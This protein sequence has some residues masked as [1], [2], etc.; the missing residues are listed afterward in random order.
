MD[1]L[2]DAPEALLR[3]VY[4]LCSS[5]SPLNFLD[6]LEKPD[7]GMQRSTH[8][9]R[10]THMCSTAQDT[11]EFAQTEA[12]CPRGGRPSIEGGAGLGGTGGRCGTGQRDRTGVP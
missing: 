3:A 7:T 11:L 9:R 12:V 10:H 6:L 1:R 5:V 2:S 4:I 8:R